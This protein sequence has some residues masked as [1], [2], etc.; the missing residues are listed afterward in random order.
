MKKPAGSK[1]LQKKKR[2]LSGKLE[3]KKKPSSLRVEQIQRLQK[4]MASLNIA[5]AFTDYRL[6]DSYVDCFLRRYENAQ[7]EHGFIQAAALMSLFDFIRKKFPD[8]GEEDL[9]P[10]AQ[11]LYPV[12]RAMIEHSGLL[13][14]IKKAASGKLPSGRKQ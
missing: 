6:S 7:G 13:K 1:E 2:R 12:V 8:M 9:V 4:E 3:M 5:E 11:Q 14:L 10:K